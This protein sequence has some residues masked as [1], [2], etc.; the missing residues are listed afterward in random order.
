MMVVFKEY[1]YK[2]YM[3]FALIVG[4]FVLFFFPTPNAFFQLLSGIIFK[5]MMLLAIYFAFLSLK[6]EIMLFAFFFQIFK[7]NISAIKMQLYYSPNDINPSIY[8]I[9]TKLGYIVVLLFVLG[10]LNMFNKYPVIGSVSSVGKIHILAYSSFTATFFL[11]TII[12]LCLF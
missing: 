3:Y 10:H 1:D 4:A 8:S 5:M 7:L 6:K 2:H 11:Q 9:D 12:Y